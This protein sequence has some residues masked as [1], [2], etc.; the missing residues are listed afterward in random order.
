MSVCIDGRTIA[1]QMAVYNVDRQ[2]SY[3]CAANI[4]R[5]ILINNKKII[6]IVY[7]DYRPKTS[8]LG[9]NP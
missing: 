2:D 3:L 9:V 8:F 1:I 4:L 7:V 6:M 5:H